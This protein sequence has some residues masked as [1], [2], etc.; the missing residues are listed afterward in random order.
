MDLVARTVKADGSIVDMKRDAVYQ[1]DLVRAGGRKVKVKSFAVPGVEPGAIVEYRYTEVRDNP[2]MFY[3]RVQM[4]REYPV[5]KV[6]YYVKPLSRDYTTYRMSVWPFNCKPSPLKLE[7]N[8]YNSF[9]LENVPAF[10]E[11]PLMLAEANVRAWALLFYRDDD[12]REPD[13]YWGEIGKKYYDRLKLALKANNELKQTVAEVITGA[14]T[15]EEKVS[16]LIGYLRKHT[17]GFYDPGVTDAE[18]AQVKMPKDRQR[19][20]AEVLKSGLGTPDERNLLFA[21]MA[22]AAG[23]E[24]RPALLPSRQDILFNQRMTDVYFLDSVD[25]AVK[26]GDAWKLYD[27]SARDLPPGMLSWP[28]ED[29]PVLLSDPK[30]PSF[31]ASQPAS[32]ESSRIHRTA[33]LSLSEDGTLEGDIE[34]TS[35]GHS[36]ADRR[37]EL[38]GESPE[39]QEE[40]VKERV[41]A[42]FAQA[43]VTGIGVKNVDDPTQP[44]L[45]HYHVKIPGYA[46]RTAKRILLQPL[47]FQRGDAPRFTAATRRYLISFPYAWKESDSISLTL[48]PGF[49]LDAAEA[50]A[51]M[52]FGQPGS[53][54][55]AVKPGGRELAITRELT[56]GDH[57]ILNF[58]PEVYPQLK[59]VFD[60]IYGRDN[61]AI[62][63]TQSGGEQ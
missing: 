49:K 29:V 13:K 62:S 34:E 6:T 28:E 24:T 40:K 20:A 42:V 4:Q 43:E 61:R 5:Q 44:L 41:V 12:K 30:K 26:I 45:V 1:R 52:N 27:V 50:P 51:Q 38:E 23:L 10:Q 55:V 48:P 59:H 32:P 21:A 7:N 33:K 36:G 11:E 47:Y 22:A 18:R 37:Q 57:G 17:R 8:G 46:A 3:A 25:M 35:T 63:L 15:D 58:Q 9:T 2:N 31:I 60:E 39:R 16:A 19:T 53:Y 54:A 56:F 14:Q